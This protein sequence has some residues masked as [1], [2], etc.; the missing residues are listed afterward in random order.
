MQDAVKPSGQP[1]PAEPA[2]GR[3]LSARERGLEPRGVDASSQSS[4]GEDAASGASRAQQ[5]AHA[6]GSKF[7]KHSP[8]R[9]PRR[10]NY[11]KLGF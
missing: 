10:V 4:V 6:S 11:D 9:A 7:L 8:R 2:G 1:A 3:A 5:E